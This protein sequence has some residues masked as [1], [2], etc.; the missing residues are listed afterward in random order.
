MPWKNPSV[1]AH[2]IRIPFNIE[3]GWPAAIPGSSVIACEAGATLGSLYLEDE[4]WRTLQGE[5][6]WSLRIDGEEPDPGSGFV[7]PTAPVQVPPAAL[8]NSRCMNEWAMDVHGSVGRLLT[9]GASESW[10]LVNDADLELTLIC[11]PPSQFQ[12]EFNKWSRRPFQWV[13]STYWGQSGIRA[14]V[15]LSKRFALEWST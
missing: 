3:D 12:I 11:S 4:S 14:V 6:I 5:N 7:M 13:D 15:D 2:F 9:W 10:W 8:E 1:C